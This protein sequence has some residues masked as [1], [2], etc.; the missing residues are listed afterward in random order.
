MRLSEFIDKMSKLI[1]KL[2]K[3]TGWIFISTVDRLL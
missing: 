3:K 2:L 1:D